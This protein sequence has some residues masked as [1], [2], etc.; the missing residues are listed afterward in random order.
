MMRKFGA[1]TIG[2][3]LLLG[4]LLLAPLPARANP[5]V[6]TMDLYGSAE[7]GWGLLSSS[8]SNPGPHISGHQGDTVTITLHSTDGFPHRFF[9]DY[10]NNTL[11]SGT[12][13]ASSSFTTTTTITFTATQV[14]SFDYYCEFHPTTM[15]GDFVVEASGSPGTTTSANPDNT[16]LIVGAL[17]A[18]VAAV[19]VGGLLLMR[20]KA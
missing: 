2:V 9:V 6:V 5:G 15:K 14:G 8:E 4:L 7:T 11:V 17:V 10:D 3:G 1:A 18:V 12:D 19:G 16:L 20:R 13:P